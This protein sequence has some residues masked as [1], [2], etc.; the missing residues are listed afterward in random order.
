MRWVVNGTTW[1]LYPRER[2]PVRTVQEARWVPLP[3][4]TGAGNLAPTVTRYPDCPAFSESQYRLRYPGPCFNFVLPLYLLCLLGVWYMSYF[5]R[6]ASSKMPNMLIFYVCHST[7][8]LLRKMLFI[9]LLRTVTHVKKLRSYYRNIVTSKQFRN[10]GVHTRTHDS[11][12]T[13]PFKI[14]Y[15]FESRAT[16]RARIKSSSVHI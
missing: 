4:R 10:A 6:T 8:V 7:A 14:V 2:D 5:L 3:D 15:C 1:Q 16:S 12:N 9:I 13:Q 11:S